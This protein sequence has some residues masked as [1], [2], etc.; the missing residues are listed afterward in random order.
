MTARNKKVLVGMNVAER[1]LDDYVQTLSQR[2]AQLEKKRAK[3][4]QMQEIFTKHETHVQKLGADRNEALHVARNQQYIL[5]ASKQRKEG[6]DSRPQMSPLAG[7]ESGGQSS[8][9]ELLAIEP[10]GTN[11]ESNYYRSK[12]ERAKQKIGKKKQRRQLTESDPQVAFEKYLKA[13]TELVAYRSALE[14]VDGNE[15]SLIDDSRSRK[16]RWRQIRDKIAQSTNAEILNTN[17]MYG[18]LEFM[19]G[20]EILKV[21]AQ[22]YSSQPSQTDNVNILR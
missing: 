15:E 8:A 20:D 12:I 22:K 16:T 13:H 7:D 6:R 4:Q 14:T 3:V 11:R 19:H 10:V 1:D 17:N 18:H 2:E 9:E 5:I 21:F